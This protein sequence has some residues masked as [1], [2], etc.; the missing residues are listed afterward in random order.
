MSIDFTEHDASTIEKV[1]N[2]VVA[3]VYRESHLDVIDKPFYSVERFV[4]RVRG[5]IKAPGFGLVAAYSNNIAV[6]LAFGYAL[7][8]NARWWEGLTT[9]VPEG[10]TAETGK[11]T[12]A[13]NELMV[14]PVWQG[15]G[16]AR[17]LHDRLLGNRH[18]QRATLLVRE[19]NERAL[20][21]YAKWGWQ[22]V[23]KLRPYPDAPHFD[24]MVLPLPISTRDTSSS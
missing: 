7:P 13:L 5:Y 4:E 15:R 10:F 6:G 18:E 16:V 17:A 2:T 12:F 24:A 1:L 11:R 23:G 9:P 21:R 19:D 20:S 8:A 22:K 14:V 3:R